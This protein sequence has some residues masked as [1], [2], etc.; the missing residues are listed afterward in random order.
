MDEVKNTKNTQKNIIKHTLRFF[1][2]TSS[3]QI[4]NVKALKNV[5]TY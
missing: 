3:H 2:R 4:N 1:Y 5:V